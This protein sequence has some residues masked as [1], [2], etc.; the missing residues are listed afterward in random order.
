[1]FGDLTSELLPSLLLKGGFVSSSI[2]RG[3]AM[4]NYEI[5]NIYASNVMQKSKYHMMSLLRRDLN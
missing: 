3:Y 5:L 4:R 2:H 1:M